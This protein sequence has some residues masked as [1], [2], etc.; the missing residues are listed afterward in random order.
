VKPWSL[1]RQFIYS[2]NWSISIREATEDERC[3]DPT[4]D[5]VVVEHHGYAA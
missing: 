4:T 5:G 2:V 1:L 3:D